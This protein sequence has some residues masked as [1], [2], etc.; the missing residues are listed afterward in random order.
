VCL[1]CEGQLADDERRVCSMCWSSI[2]RVSTH[3][4]LYRQQLARLTAQGLVEGLI[5][6]YHFEK[7]GTLQTLIHSL[8]YHGITHLGVEFGRKLGDAF[9]DEIV[10]AE[11]NGIIPVPLHRAK[12]RERGYN[13]SDHIARGL[14]ESTGIE[15]LLNLVI[16]RKYTRSQAQLNA[17]ERRENV[18][19]A[20][21]I[22]PSRVS[23]IRDG[24]FLLVDDVITTGATVESCAKVFIDNG[25][26]SIIACSVALAE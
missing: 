13:Q 4:D 20:F 16:R 8:K 6:L 3:D 1:A 12:L 10:E 22:H 21:E 17:Q 26:K 23:V 2:R 25:A 14:F 19:D 9:R 7:D 18:G 11:V 5:S 24:T 15:V